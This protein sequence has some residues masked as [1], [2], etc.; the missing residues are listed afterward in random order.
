MPS[1]NRRHRLSGSW[2]MPAHESWGGAGSPGSGSAGG[3]N[4]GRVVDAQARAH[5]VV[6]NVVR[7]ERR[8]LREGARFVEEPSQLVALEEEECHLLLPW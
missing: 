6:L 1:R 3:S 5:A 7:E 4:E 2:R 8:E